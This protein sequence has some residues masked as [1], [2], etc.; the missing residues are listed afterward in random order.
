VDPV[1]VNAG[2]PGYTVNDWDFSY[3][4]VNLNLVYRWEYRPGSTFYLVWTQSRNTYEDRYNMGNAHFSPDIGGG[5]AFH[6]E[7]ENRVLAK[8]TYWI[9][10]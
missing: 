1:N 8:V 7:P 5:Q 6:N 4:A 10:I 3:A 9:A 2:Q